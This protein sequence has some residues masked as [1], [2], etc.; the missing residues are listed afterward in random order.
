LGNIYKLII[1]SDLYDFPKI[2]T[3]SMKRNISVD[4]LTDL[5]NSTLKMDQKSKLKKS[6]SVDSLTEY[7]LSEFG[8]NKEIIS[9]KKTFSAD[10]LSDLT[11]IKLDNEFDLLTSKMKKN[12]S[13]DSLPEICTS[14]NNINNDVN[15]NKRKFEDIDTNNN[16]KLKK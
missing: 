7:S 16:K 4:S 11:I 3:P 15:D 5:S 9:M 2:D 6:T 14:N 8:I 1:L 13:Y 10:S 12:F